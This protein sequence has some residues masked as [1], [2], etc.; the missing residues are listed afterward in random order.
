[1]IKEHPLPYRKKCAYNERK[2]E[3]FIAP[4]EWRYWWVKIDL[5]F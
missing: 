2:V 1:M 4:T 3:V 5:L